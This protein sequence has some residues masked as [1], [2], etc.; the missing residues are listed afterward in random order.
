MKKVIAKTGQYIISLTKSELKE[1]G[2]EESDINDSSDVFREFVDELIKSLNRNKGKD[3]TESDGR[4]NITISKGSVYIGLMNDRAKD[5]RRHI[6]EISQEIRRIELE[7]CI[8]ECPFDDIDEDGFEELEYPELKTIVMSFDKVSML[9]GF[10]KNNRFLASILTDTYKDT[11]GHYLLST[12][13]ADQQVLDNIAESAMTFG[14]REIE[15]PPSAEYMNEH[16]KKLNTLA[17][18]TIG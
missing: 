12:S 18:A 3:I 4:V 10:L 2:I 6:F 5:I 7:S 16:F 13:F 15:C 14:G 1:Q 11:Q 8:E 9:M 17:L